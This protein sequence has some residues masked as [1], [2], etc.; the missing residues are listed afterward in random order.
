M[1]YAG[2]SQIAISKVFQVQPHI[3]SLMLFV[4]STPKQRE[5]MKLLEK[6]YREIY[7]NGNYRKSYHSFLSDN[8]PQADTDEMGYLSL[9]AVYAG[10]D[11][12]NA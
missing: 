3:I 4:I 11:E 1:Y 2:V 7:I 8:L 6:E 5:E 10:G 9:S 12:N